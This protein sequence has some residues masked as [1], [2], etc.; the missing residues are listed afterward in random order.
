MRIEV[1]NSVY[2]RVTKRWIPVRVCV[3]QS[4]CWSKLHSS[5]TQKWHTQALKGNQQTAH[6]TF[7]ITCSDCVHQGLNYLMMNWGGRKSGE[8]FRQLH[9]E[10]CEAPRKNK[11]SAEQRSCKW[12][13]NEAVQVGAGDL[14]WMKLRGIEG[15]RLR[16]GLCSLYNEQM[17]NQTLTWW[18]V[19]EQKKLGSISRTEKYEPTHQYVF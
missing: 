6:G 15:K 8:V 2:L 7:A 13:S 18:K 5:L 19:G 17:T 16:A 11:E 3:G 9:R 1:I 14:L 4:W 10:D 12:G